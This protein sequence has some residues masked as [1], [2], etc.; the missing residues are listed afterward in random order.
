ME[1]GSHHTT[2]PII[3]TGPAN[4][5][6]FSH[7]GNRLA[8]AGDRG[9]QV[10]NWDDKSGQPTGDPLT[11]STDPAS[12]LAFSHDEPASQRRRPRHTGVEL[13]R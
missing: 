7:D 1:Y 12:D 9:I 8:I 13:G 4:A 5:A 3:P 6:A 11:I 2:P 10:W